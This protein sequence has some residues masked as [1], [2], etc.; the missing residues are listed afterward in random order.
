MSQSRSVTWAGIT[1]KR[2][3]PW[4]IRALPRPVIPGSALRQLGISPTKRETFEYAGGERVELEIAEAR[5]RGRAR[6]DDLGHIRG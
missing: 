3:T 4:W 2:W 5:A 6:D 1:S